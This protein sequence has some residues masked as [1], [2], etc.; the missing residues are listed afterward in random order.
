MG[1]FEEMP[2]N[3][4]QIVNRAMG[5]KK[6]LRMPMRLET[7]HLSFPLSGRLARHLGPVVFPFPLRVFDSGRNLPAGCA[8]AAQLIG[9]HLVWA[10]TQTL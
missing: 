1:R 9:N 3:P 7:T 4:K 10:L 5:G 2:P 6:L 8:K